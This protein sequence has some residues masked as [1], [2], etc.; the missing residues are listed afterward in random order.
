MDSRLCGSD[1]PIHSHSRASGNPSS[2]VKIH[3][4]FLLDNKRHGLL[5]GKYILM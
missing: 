2:M 4:D 1:N 5:Q 3:H